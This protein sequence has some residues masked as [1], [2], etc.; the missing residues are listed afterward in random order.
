MIRRANNECNL[1]RA[2]PFAP[3][4]RELAA[5]RVIR[6]ACV[7]LGALLALAGAAAH[8]QEGDDDRWVESGRESLRDQGDYPWYDSEG[9]QVRRIDLESD[10]EDAGGPMPRSGVSTFLGELLGAIVRS[11]FWIF[12][13]VV[14]AAVA[15]LIIWALFRSDW[16]QAKEQKVRVTTSTGVDRVD[17]LPVPMPPTGDL[18]AE[19]RR[20]YEAGRYDEAIV[21]LYG[22]QLVH[23]DKHQLIRLARGKTNRQYLR[24]LRKHPS[25]CDRL[26]MTM[27]AFED[28]YFGRHALPRSRFESVWNLLPDFHRHVE[29]IAA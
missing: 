9:D 3:R 19:A 26:E 18:L 11:I 25:V 1:S 21:Y 24:E 28:A 5:P 10:A 29:Q 14:F 2:A 12:L 7:A 17:D 6:A 22:H 23:L 27:V 16:R 4:A 13:L 20:L 15:A 8:A